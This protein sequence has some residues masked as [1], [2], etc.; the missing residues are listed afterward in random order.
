MTH[1][2]PV[3]TTLTCECA[4]HDNALAVV[5]GGHACCNRPLQARRQIT[6]PLDDT[7][8]RKLHSS[9]EPP[10]HDTYK[11]RSRLRDPEQHQGP[12]T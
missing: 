6:P 4:C 12:S 1:A 2:G 8:L 5:G 7:Q 3:L 11:G 10:N 9:S